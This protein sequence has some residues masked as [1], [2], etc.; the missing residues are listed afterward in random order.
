LLFELRAIAWHAI[1]LTRPLSG[2]SSSFQETGQ[3]S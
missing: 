1:L 3:L 2:L